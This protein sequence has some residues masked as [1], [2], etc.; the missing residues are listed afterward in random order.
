M[1]GFSNNP[2]GWVTIIVNTRSYKFGILNILRE[3]AARLLRWRR[4]Y[5]EIVFPVFAII[6]DTCL[7][8]GAQVCAILSIS[9]YHIRSGFIDPRP[10]TIKHVC[11]TRPWYVVSQYDYTSTKAH[12]RHDIVMI[13]LSSSSSHMIYLY[14]RISHQNHL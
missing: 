7:E 4:E 1:V 14:A 12:M 8:G 11:I 6:L 10:M 2:F 3:Q 9:Q 5:R 13:Y